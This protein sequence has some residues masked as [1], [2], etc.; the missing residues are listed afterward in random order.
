MDCVHTAFGNALQSCS[1][2]GHSAL[3][4]LLDFS[5]PASLLK[6]GSQVRSMCDSHANIYVKSL[7]VNF[8]FQLSVGI[9]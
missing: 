1:G 2:G 8:L 6:T 3:L 5:A 9:Y 4:L 7:E